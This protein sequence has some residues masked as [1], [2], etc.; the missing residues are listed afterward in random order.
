MR[1][2]NPDNLLITYSDNG[3]PIFFLTS[4]NV[5]ALFYNDCTITCLAGLCPTH[6]HTLSNILPTLQHLVHYQRGASYTN[7]D[8][9]C[10]KTC[11][12]LTQLSVDLIDPLVQYPWMRTRVG[13]MLTRAPGAM[14]PLALLAQETTITTKAIYS[15]AVATW[16]AAGWNA[17]SF[18]CHGASSHHH[19]QSSQLHRFF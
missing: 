17:G 18:T 9:S 2:E 10:F 12:Q 11:L 13:T 6:T 19:T 15:N 1:G 7:Y 3:T 8:A 4:N 5:F 14:K 16:R